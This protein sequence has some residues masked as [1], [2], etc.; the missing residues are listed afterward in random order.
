MIV[1][2]GVCFFLQRNRIPSG[3][4]STNCACWTFSE[5]GLMKRNFSSFFIREESA[6]SPLVCSLLVQ[7]KMNCFDRYSFYQ[8]CP[9]VLMAFYKKDKKQSQ[10]VFWMTF[11]LKR[12][13]LYNK[14]RVSCHIQH[15]SLRHLRSDKLR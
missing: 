14:Q 13:A 8:G 7:K 9:Y 12:N 3:E 6:D 11:H 5:A 15:V 10:Q 2:F 4:R 1:T